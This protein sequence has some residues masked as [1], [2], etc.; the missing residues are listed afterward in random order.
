MSTSDGDSP[1]V[2]SKQWLTEPRAFWA[3]LGGDMSRVDYISVTDYLR[4]ET[5]RA[6]S[7]ERLRVIR[8]GYNHG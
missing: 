5:A 3:S 6:E 4:R 1:E 2:E 7:E 8:E